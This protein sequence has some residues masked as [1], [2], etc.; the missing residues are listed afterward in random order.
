MFVGHYGVAF[1]ARGAEPRI[2]LWLFFLAVQAVDVLWCVLVL[3]GVEK[4]SIV[5]GI[6]PSTPLR[7]D[8]Y[9]YTHS[10]MAAIGWSAVAFGL[11]RFATRYQGSP[12]PAFILALAVASHW[13]L[14]LVV[15][16]PDLD[17][18]DE[19]FKVGLGL[20]DY[21]WTEKALEL[22]IF[23]GGLA[24]YLSRRRELN[25]NHRAAAIVLCLLLAGLQLGSD[26]GPPPSVRIVVASGLVLYLLLVLAAFFI[27]RPS[28]TAVIGRGP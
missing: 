9:P 27:E 7:F 25:R 5:P 20:W 12:R 1:A 3:A 23:F 18:T 4:V 24:Y 28:S 21:P 17:L 16:N 11:Y 13:F 2:P 14:D 6:S 10:L 19:N 8:Y 15:H 22:A 26:A